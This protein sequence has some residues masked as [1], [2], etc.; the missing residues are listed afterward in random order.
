MHN[1]H[2]LQ[3]TTLMQFTLACLFIKSLHVSITYVFFVMHYLEYPL[4]CAPL[5]CNHPIKPHLG[6][7][8]GPI[9][10]HKDR[11]PILSHLYQRKSHAAQ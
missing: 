9:T 10:E 7:T 11:I 8:Q 1:Y 2:S 4:H 5:F 6:L 3:S